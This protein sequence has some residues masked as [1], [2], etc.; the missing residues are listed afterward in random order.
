MICLSI[1]FL[2]AFEVQFLKPSMLRPAFYFLCGTT[3]YLFP[4]IGIVF[5]LE[6]GIH[7]FQVK[8]HTIRLHQCLKKSVKSHMPFLEEGKDL[9]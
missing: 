5:P 4:Y 7:S 3:S 2:Q 1:S 9:S 8:N 6:V